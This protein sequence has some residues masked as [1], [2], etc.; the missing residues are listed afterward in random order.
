[1]TTDGNPREEAKRRE[2]I[3]VA[4]K[5]LAAVPESSVTGP[6]ES[7][8]E[9]I[10]DLVCAIT[11]PPPAEVLTHLITVGV[12]GRRGGASTKLGNVLLSPRKLLTMVGKT[13]LGVTGLLAKPWIAPFVV[14]VLWDDLYS[15]LKVEISEREAN[16]VWT[17][18]INRDAESYVSKAALLSL[19]NSE[20]RLLDRAALS[21]QELDDALAI[22]KKMKCITESRNRPD[23]WFICEWVQVKF[24]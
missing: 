21:Q 22:L 10:V 3:R 5:A 4:A 7:V 9:E 24:T 14:L 12:G 18:W 8:A 16:V 15:R 11:P 1:M 13:T 17:L 2:L 20:R 19:V 6:P 23:S